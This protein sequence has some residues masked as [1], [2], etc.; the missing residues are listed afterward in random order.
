MSTPNPTYT[1]AQMRAYLHGEMPGEAA[2]EMEAALSS[3]PLLAGAMERLEAELDRQAR[4]PEELATLESAFRDAIPRQHIKTKPF[5][6][7][8]AVAAGVA[9]LAGFLFWSNFANKPADPQQLFAEN[10]MPYEDVI[11]QRSGD[12]KTEILLQQAMRAYN[13]EAYVGAS[14][15]FR[16]LLIEEPQT[17]IVNLYYSNSL[18]ATGKSDLALKQTR[19][20]LRQGEPL[21]HPAARWY[22]GLAYLQKEDIDK[23]KHVL[24]GLAAEG[25]VFGERA[26]ALLGKL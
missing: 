6:P 22:E 2:A 20:L 8:M 4:S 13:N 26:E 21:L 5:W 18:L 25:G 15:A 1:L 12:S 17:S 16:Q 23:A 24:G 11:T 7:M 14:E 3:D 19:L 9:L 10:F